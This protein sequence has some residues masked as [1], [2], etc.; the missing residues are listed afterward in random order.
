ML[1]ISLSSSSVLSLA[2]S[3]VNPN[4]LYCFSLLSNMC[5]N[6]QVLECIKKH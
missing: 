6:P 3:F 2:C 5:A 4:L 1:G